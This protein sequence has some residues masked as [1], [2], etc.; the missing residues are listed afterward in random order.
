MSEPRPSRPSLLRRVARNLARAT[1]PLWRPMAG[2]RLLPA[3]GVV[4]HRG[5][6]TGREYSTPVQV[7][8]TPDEFVIALPFGG[9][10]QWVR[11][12][13][14]AGSC[15]VTWR[16]RDHRADAPRI[17]GRTEG[18]SAFRAWERP[19]L[20]IGGI[21]SFVRLRRRADAATDRG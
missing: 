19:L 6:R 16:G 5:R 21:E 12:V 13:K 11:N 18:A 17:V 2:R 20:R 7:R 14:S 9:A 15:T 4:H 8:A 3:W 10:T 1:S